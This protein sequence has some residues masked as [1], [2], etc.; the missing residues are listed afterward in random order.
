MDY[1]QTLAENLK[2][3]RDL[4]TEA[5]LRAGR[6][7]EDVRLVAVTKTFPPGAILAAWDAGQRDFGEN[8]PEE[9][10]TKIPEIEAALGTARP[11]WHMIGP[12]QRRKAS[13]VVTHFDYVH[14][15]DRREVAQKLSTLAIAAGK[16]LPILL[17]C[18]VSGEASKHGYPV[19]GWEQ[20]ETVRATFFAEIAAVGA[21]PGLRLSGLMT[22]APIVPAA[23]DARP[24]F[25]SLR[26]LRDALQDHFPAQ[27]FDQLSMGMSDDF[28]VAVEEGATLVRVGRAIFGDYHRG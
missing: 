10:A 20:N 25:T 6:Q 3:V 8:R 11:V 9:G 24:I 13:L 21:L 4:I 5:A 14:S 26:A 27:S 7:P 23:E 12:I 2:R 28:P 15:V 1:T 22:M 16:T 18:N 17:E 19:A